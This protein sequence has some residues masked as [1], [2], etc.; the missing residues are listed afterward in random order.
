MSRIAPQYITTEAGDRLAV[1]P[2]VE[3]Q[4]LIEA[5][6]DRA[7][8]DDA[9]LILDRIASGEEEL[10]PSEFIHRL[11]VGENAV[12]V[13]REFRGMTAGNL[14][15]RAGIS[16]SELSEIE[17]DVSDGRLGT[18]KKIADALRVSVDDLV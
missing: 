7:D 14:A 2:E 17:S 10:I 11:I 9:R 16:E 13:W 6:E 18:I 12:K 5:L 15:E 8:V 4:R 3:Y 1:I